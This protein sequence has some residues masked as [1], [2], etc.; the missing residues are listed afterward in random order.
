[1]PEPTGSEPGYR[2]PLV[3]IQSDAFNR[4]RI[5]TVVAVVLTSNLKLADAPGNFLLDRTKS[6]LRADSVI[7]VSQL[8]TVE[9][10]FLTERAGKLT[11]TQ[12]QRLEAGLRL[13]LSL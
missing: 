12:M 1:M 13:V 4:S 2:R 5:Q 9:K 11:S 8:M 10:T 7:N 3:I 6:G